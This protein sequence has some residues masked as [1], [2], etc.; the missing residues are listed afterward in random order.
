MTNLKQLVIRNTVAELYSEPSGILCES[1]RQFKNVI[2][3][4]LELG[5]SVA[6]NHTIEPIDDVVAVQTT[7]DRT[8]EVYELVSTDMDAHGLVQ[9]KSFMRQLKRLYKRDDLHKYYNKEMFFDIIEQVFGRNTTVVVRCDNEDETSVLME[10]LDRF[11]IERDTI[12][13]DMSRDYSTTNYYFLA[14]TGFGSDNVSVVTIYLKTLMFVISLY[15]V[16]I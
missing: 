13:D 1:K 7:T 11:N 10:I 2:A 8:F 3:E 16:D 9:Y 5:F 12:V 15:N 14:N 6:L 4:L